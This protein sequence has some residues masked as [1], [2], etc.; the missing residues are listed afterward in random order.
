MVGNY[1][2]VYQVYFQQ[3]ASLLYLLS[4]VYIS[5]TRPKVARWVVMCQHNARCQHLNSQLQY[6]L[7]VYNSAR[8]PTGAY[9]LFADNL[10][11][12]V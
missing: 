11:G 3:P 12:A 7:I 5:L 1:Q 9:L 6:Y 8:Y 2:M 4:Q 10:V